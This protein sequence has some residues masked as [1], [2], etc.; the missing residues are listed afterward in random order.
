MNINELRSIQQSAG[1]EYDSYK[2]ALMVC[3]GT[4]CVANKALPLIDALKEELLK[5]HLIQED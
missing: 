5:I 2:S 1:K 4:A 3:A